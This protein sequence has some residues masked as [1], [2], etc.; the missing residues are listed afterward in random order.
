MNKVILTKKINESKTLDKEVILSWVSCL[1]SI[2]SKTKPSEYL[3][4]DVFMHEIFRHPYVLLKKTKKGWICGL[5]TSDAD[6]ADILEPCQSRFFVDNYFARTLFITQKPLG[7]FM[8]VYEN[9]KHLRDVYKA[10]QTYFI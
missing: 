6:Y 8:A 2:G 1:P 3:V 9:K 5:I 10:L 7:T 4:G